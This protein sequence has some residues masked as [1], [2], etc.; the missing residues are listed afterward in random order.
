MLPTN[1]FLCCYKKNFQ[2][3]NN[4]FTYISSTTKKCRNLLR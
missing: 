1:D 4:V 3:Y 2:C